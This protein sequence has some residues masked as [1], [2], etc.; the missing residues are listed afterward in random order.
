MFQYAYAKA[1][2][3][4]GYDVKIDISAFE[5]YQL[6]G[7]YQLD[8]YNIDLR[9]STKEENRRYEH[10]NFFSKFLMKLGLNF[11][12][13]I[14]EKN[15]LFDK[16]LLI[17]VNNRY[18]EG[19]FQ[20]EKYFKSIRDI[21]I[22]QFIIKNDLSNYSQSILKLIKANKNTCS[23]HVRRGDFTKKSNKTIHGIC[24]LK[25]YNKAID[26]IKNINDET[27]FFIFSDDIH[28]CE[29][30]LTFRKGIFINSFEKR[31]PH[32]DIY[33][34][35]LCNDNIISNSTFGWWGAWL[36]ENKNKKVIAPKRWFS[37][38][39]LEQQS[40]MIVCDSWVRL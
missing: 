40:R 14:I 15:L 21:I 4:K 26:Q 35:S 5:N 39:I 19:Y 31:I 22:S 10:K 18:V 38:N 20:S 23:I 3:L 32:E 16:S 12:K 9:V 28:W 33:L 11:S 27:I 8:L 13:K 24:D 25:Y 1:L 37:N 7:G 2:K 34:M 17:L 36:N 6:H 29:K 30:N